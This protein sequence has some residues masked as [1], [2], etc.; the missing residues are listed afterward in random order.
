MQQHAER[1]FSEK[2]RSANQEDIAALENFCG[3][4]LAVVQQLSEFQFVVILS[5]HFST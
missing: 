1:H 2:P 5:R 3:R 4:Q